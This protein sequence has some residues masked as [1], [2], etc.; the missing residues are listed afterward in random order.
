MVFPLAP[1]KSANCWIRFLSIHVMPVAPPSPGIA[2]QCSQKMRITEFGLLQQH[3]A[4]F[5]I[6]LTCFS[7][8]LFCFMIISGTFFPI[9]CLST[10]FLWVLYRRTHSVYWFLTVSTA[11]QFLQTNPTGCVIGGENLW[12]L[13]F[14][15]HLK[16]PNQSLWN[17]K[18]TLS[19]MLWNSIL[20]S[21]GRLI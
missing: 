6:V 11:L 4:S 15:M 14:S 12:A 16:S 8:F 9:L 7:A 13:K 21:M 19:P 3:T 1:S 17:Q 10:R 5:D 20:K 2:G 18:G